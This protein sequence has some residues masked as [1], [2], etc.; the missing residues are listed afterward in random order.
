MCNGVKTARCA[1]KRK[2]QKTPHPAALRQELRCSEQGISAMRRA[3]VF[4]C[5]K[6]FFL[7]PHT[8]FFFF[9]KKV[10]DKEKEKD[11]DKE[12]EQEKENI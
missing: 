5:K 4:M 6:C 12:K 2:A 1:K 8:P 7:F 11:K 10:K 3:Y 9:F